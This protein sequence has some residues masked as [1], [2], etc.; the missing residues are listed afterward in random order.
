[1]TELVQRAE[2]A[3]LVARTTSADDGRVVNL[4]LT[5][6]GE[7]RL[8]VVHDALGPERVHLRAMIDRLDN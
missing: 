2:A 4:R 3:G 6:E 7:E 1:M 8:A 5:P